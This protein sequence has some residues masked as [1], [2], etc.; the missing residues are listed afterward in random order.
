MELAPTGIEMRILYGVCGEG[1]GHAIRSSIVARHLEQQGHQIRFASTGRALEFLR[2]R[3]PQQVQKIH[4]LGFQMHRNAVD[5]LET[6]CTGL[7]IAT[8]TQLAHSEKFFEMAAHNPQIVLTDFEPST[9]R[10]AKVYGLPLIAIDHPHF[11]SKCI[12]PP[13]A[14]SE[15][16][17]AAALAYPIVDNM[18]EADRYLIT[19]FAGAKVC[20]PNTTLHLPAIRDEI[21]R[22]KRQAPA[23]GTHVVCYFNSKADHREILRV[24]SHVRNVEFRVYGGTSH[25]SRTRHG[26]LLVCPIS[27]TEFIEDLGSSAA[28][29]GGGGFNFM[30]EA[31]YLEKPMLSLPFG[32]HYEQIL[33]AN[34]LKLLGFGERCYEF[35]PEVV[36]R[37]LGS[38][39]VYRARLRGLRHDDN[40]E[41][42]AS[43]DIALRSA[44]NG[45]R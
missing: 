44:S 42:L 17:G 36:R 26:N 20:A 13:A 2:K 8:V 24:L 23:E 41:L 21:I 43:V 4:G 39:P 25:S 14:F 16:R 35:T 11:V 6:I 9:A 15:D 10:F 30:S 28:I 45:Y 33:N 12:H 32:R 37:F 38:A 18:M 34:Y 31:L 27:E 3:W 1:M 7:F 29:I 40:R 22:T 19:T 5:T